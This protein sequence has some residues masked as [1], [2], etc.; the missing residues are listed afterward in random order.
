MLEGVNSTIY[1]DGTQPVRWWLRTDSIGESCARLCPAIEDRRRPAER[2]D[3]RPTCWTGSISTR[4]CSRRIPARAIS[5][6]PLGAR[7][8]FAL[9]RQRYQ[10]HS[11]LHGHGGRARHRSLGRSAAAEHRGQL[12]YHRHAT[13]FAAGALTTASCCNTV[14]SSYWRARTI[15]YAPH[16]EA[17]IWASYLW[18]YDKTKD[19]I[20]VGAHPK[21]DPHDD[22][23]LSR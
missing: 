14:G 5:A 17:W 18:A 9:R 16:Y 12:P 13:V 1:Y 15:H 3:R 8:Y 2:Q 6:G 20:A 10:D 11:R 23:G 21:C 4:A 19:P 22:G 7:Q